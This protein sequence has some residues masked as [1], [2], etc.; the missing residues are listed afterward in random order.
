MQQNA[1][2]NEFNREYASL[3]T[4]QLVIAIIFTVK[5]VND[6]SF[7]LNNSCLHELV[8]IN[9]ADRSNI[10]ANTAAPINLTQ[11]LMFCE[12]GLD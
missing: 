4:I 3:A 9:N 10:D 12:I 5:G 11:Q 7:D 2:E 1:I 8:K 6:L